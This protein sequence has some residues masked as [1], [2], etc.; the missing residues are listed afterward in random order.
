MKFTKLKTFHKNKRE[1][2][3]N[4][5]TIHK[6]MT[7]S[8]K[9]W[10]GVLLSSNFALNFNIV[11]YRKLKFYI[12]TAEKLCQIGFYINQYHNDQKIYFF[13]L[14]S[15]EMGNDVFLINFIRIPCKYFFN[16]DIYFSISKR[17]SGSK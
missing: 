7:L 3:K 11:H 16:S 9:T 14:N 10:T 1:I 17:I 2:Y 4:K 5:N 12:L 13:L 6:N 8:K 15:L